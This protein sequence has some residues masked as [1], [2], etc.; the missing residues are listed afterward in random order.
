VALEDM[1]RDFRVALEIEDSH[2]GMIK[3]Q[4][5]TAS[6]A[7]F[8]AATSH[9]QENIIRVAVVA[10]SVTKPAAK[11]GIPE[12][13]QI[14]GSLND[15]QQIFG[16][17]TNGSDLAFRMRMFN[18]RTGTP[19]FTELTDFP[20]P[21]ESLEDLESAERKP[22][23]IA[24]GDSLLRTFKRCHD[25][26]YGN[27]SMRGDRAFWQLLYL[28][29]AKILD[30]QQSR[31]AFFVGATEGNTEEGRKRVAKRIR[32]LFDDAKTRAYKDVFDGSERIELNERALTY[33]AGELGRYV[34]PDG[35]LAGDS[36]KRASPSFST[37]K[38]PSTGNH[39]GK[40]CFDPHP[41]VACVTGGC[42]NARR[43][44]LAPA[45]LAGQE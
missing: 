16:L 25:Y 28:I 37:T 7:V 41:L 24:S 19:E 9:S 4:R 45:I 40:G 32:G 22:L 38:S 10:K 23:R 17:W 27:Q 39:A 31:R 43:L 34:F 26:L 12:L 8:E 13:E 1:E 15:R 29:F 14:L 3:V 2:S 42:R 18:K 44:G 11:K 35:T 30:E 33:I 36:Q 5:K 20:A 21:D 6:L